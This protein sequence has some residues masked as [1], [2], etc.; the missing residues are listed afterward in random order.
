MVYWGDRSSCY[1]YYP[2]THPRVQ[3]L[4]VNGLVSQWLTF[5]APVN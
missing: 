1:D 5:P 3:V 4:F 2:R